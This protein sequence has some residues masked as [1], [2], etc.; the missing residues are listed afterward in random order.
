MILLNREADTETESASET[1]FWY[2]LLLQWL[3]LR[4][5]RR[6]EEIA[7]GLVR[8]IRSTWSVLDGRDLDGNSLEWARS[9]VSAIQRAFEDSQQASDVFV[10]EVRALE[11]PDAPLLPGH[12]LASDSVREGARPL[13]PHR[14]YL[15]GDQREVLAPFDERKA[16]LEMLSSGPAYVKHLMPAPLDEAMESGLASAQGKAIELALQG[17]RELVR[18]VVERDVAAIGWRRVTDSDPC[19][20]CALLA[21]RGTVFKESSFVQSDEKFDPP[22]NMRD[23]TDG[24]MPAKVHDHCAC[25]IAPVYDRSERFSDEAL[26]WRNL[27]IDSTK[28]LRGT[29]AMSAWR[30][31]YNHELFGNQDLHRM[32][33][34]DAETLLVNI[35]RELKRRGTRDKSYSAQFLRDQA[36]LLRAQLGS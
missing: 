36:E 19:A 11:A 8:E 22:E 26:T 17:G 4:H 20:F 29:A 13:S 33:Q 30:A 21:S 27:W 1:P 14:N 7:S 15:V 2:A 23:L 35:D 24:E 34:Q 5:Q 12:L 16:G 3:A 9:T 25:S 31:A 18:D 10:R 32:T 28:G 6:Q